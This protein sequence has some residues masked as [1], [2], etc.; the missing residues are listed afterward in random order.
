MRAMIEREAGMPRWRPKRVWRSGRHCRHPPTRKAVATTRTRRLGTGR[1]AAGRVVA[2]T[3]RRPCRADGGSTCTS[4]CARSRTESASRQPRALARRRRGTRRRPAR[5]SPPSG[6]GATIRPPRRR[7]PPREIVRARLLPVAAACVVRRAGACRECRDEASETLQ[8]RMGVAH[9]AGAELGRG[10]DNSARSACQHAGR[11]RSL[12]RQAR[13]LAHLG[14]RVEESSTASTRRNCRRRNRNY[15][16]Y[17]PQIAH[18]R[19]TFRDYEMPFNADSSFWSD[20]GFM[21]WAIYAARCRR[22]SRLRSACATCHG[23]STSRWPTCAG[24]GARVLGKTR[25]RCWTARRSIAM[26]AELKDIESSNFFDPYARCRRRFLP[27]NRTRCAP[28]AFAAIRDAVV[29]AT[30]GCWRSSAASTR[31]RRNSRW[32]PRRCWTARPGTAS[33]SASTRPWTRRPTRSTRSAL[34]EV[35]AI[36]GEMDAIIRQVGFQG[37]FCRV[38]RLLRTDPRFYAKTPQELLTAPR[39]L[40]RDGDRC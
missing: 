28:R 26:I 18:G 31:R 6:P 30:H 10:H 3:T 29:P 14:R 15:A 2:R 24:P 12:I 5:L 8:G 20:L 4:G 37:S 17:R 21:V 13:R 32:P 38:H 16:V 7:M 25:A 27:L 34:R 36:R 1:G 9:A 11:R 33:R 22:P 39:G 19:G 40:R 23:I 35:A